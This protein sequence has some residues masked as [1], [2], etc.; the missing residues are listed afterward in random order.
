MERGGE[1]DVVMV[2]TNEILEVTRLNDIAPIDKDA[3]QSC[4]R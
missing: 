4:H 2:Q 3:N 1:E